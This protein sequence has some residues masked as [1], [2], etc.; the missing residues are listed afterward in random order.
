MSKSSKRTS[1]PI[2]FLTYSHDGFGLGHFQ[3]HL[4]L[5]TFLTREL[6]EVSALMLTGSSVSHTFHIPPGVDY[7]KLP[8]IT[9][10]GN[11]VY[12]AKHLSL[13]FEE[14]KAIRERIVLE[15][16]LAYQ[17]HVFLVDK[18]PL[19]IGGEVLPALN[20]LK[21]RQ[22]E[23]KV[24][25][26]LRDILDDSKVMV[27]YFRDPAIVDA[28][29]NIYDEIWVYGCKSVYDPINEY[30]LTETVAKKTK[31]CGYLSSNTPP[32]SSADIRR[33]LDID[34]SKFVLVT[35]G[36]GG[37]GFPLL[38]T[39][40]KALDFLPKTMD[41]FSLLICGPDM[42]PR[43]LANLFNKDR[44]ALKTKVSYRLPSPPA[45]LGIF[46]N[47]LPAAERP[48]TGGSAILQWSPA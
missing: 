21:E 28:M 15:T 43:E 5:A 20:A 19:G 3:R 34:G 46:A 32:L 40:L 38:D 17:P 24:V 42:P 41:I 1:G 26:G 23:T 22:A 4:K 16:A 35:A 2:R 14:I 12:T 44:V 11:E 27:P 37:D 7:V 45:R 10:E 36:G 13:T 8:C 33:K 47:G 6:P 30:Q 18:H 25:L 9:K 48:P 29:E 31:F 39:Y